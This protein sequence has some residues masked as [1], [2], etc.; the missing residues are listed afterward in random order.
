MSMLRPRT[1][2]E[3][4]AVPE[5]P[6]AEAPAPEPRRRSS[7][8][9]RWLD[10]LGLYEVSEETI[11]TSTRQAQAV[12]PALVA[13]HA[14]LAGPITGVDVDTGNAVSNGPHELYAQRRITSPNVVVLGDVG[15]AKSSLVKTVYVARAVACGKQVAVFDRKNQE[16][17]GEY[18][19]VARVCDGT[20]I[21]FSRTKGS[22]INLL[23]PRISTSSRDGDTDARIGQD[24]LLLMAAEYAHG[25]L[26]SH[27]HH[28][29]RSA[30]RT[31]LARAG[32]DGRNAT[33]HD[34]VDALYAPE[35]DAVPRAHLAESEVVTPRDVVDWGMALAMDLERFVDGDLSGLIDADTSDSVDWSAPLLVFDTSELDEDS[36]ALSLVMALVATFLSSV[37]AARPGQRI[38][39][40]EEGYH[41]AR[42][43]GPGT[44]SVAGILRSLVKRGRGIG[45]AF[46]TVIHHVS[47]LPPDSDAMSLVREAQVVHVYRQSRSDD[48]RTVVSLFG[49]PSWSED[50]LPAVEPGVHVL[51]VGKEPAR[52]VRHIRTRIEEG[53]TDTDA[54]MTGA[55]RGTAS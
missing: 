54:A 33:I 15:S 37:W 3:A 30:H 43:T 49:L 18:A 45:L 39:V 10:R 1:R 5:E 53:F 48:A 26:S 7:R 4:P 29:L 12:N 41:T 11:F 38:I 14:P 17:R 42:L 19:D 6:A 27:E 25:R 22:A 51:K 8:R 32:A 40:L 21:A 52:L 47:D 31:A 44:T 23:D 55:R 50:L 46:V 13:T 2:D 35:A 34:V 16:G 9:A 24:R 20:T 28:A 36:P